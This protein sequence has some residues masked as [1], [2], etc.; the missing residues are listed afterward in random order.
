MLTKGPRIKMESTYQP[1]FDGFKVVVLTVVH[2]KSV[3][4]GAGSS[5]K[6]VIKHTTYEVKQS[7]TIGM[8]CEKYLVV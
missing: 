6:D 1:E 4:N 5:R 8:L 7:F 2:G 3:Q